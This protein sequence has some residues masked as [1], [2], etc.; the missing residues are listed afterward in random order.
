MAH[1]FGF[2]YPTATFRKSWEDITFNHHHDTLPGSGIHSPYSEDLC[3]IGASH[4]PEQRYSNTR[5]G[6]AF[7]ARYA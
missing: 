6:N 7:A 3:G 4:R 5:H 1:L 2:E